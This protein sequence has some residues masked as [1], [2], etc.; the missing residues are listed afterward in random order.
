MIDW[1]NSYDKRL[2]ENQS[3]TEERH[4]RM[5]KTN[6]KFV[7]KNYMLQEAIDQA[8]EGDFSVVAKLFE[9]AQE[10]YDEHEGCE[11]WAGVTP[12]A[13]KNQKLSCSS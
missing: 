3:S 8:D 11:R 1:L 12:D 13:F 5:L 9:I 10:P 4:E 6:P 7:L 2:E